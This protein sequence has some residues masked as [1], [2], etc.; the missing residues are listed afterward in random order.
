[1]GFYTGTSTDYK[2]ALADL[3]TIAITTEGTWNEGTGT[4]GGRYTTSTEDEWIATGDGS[5]SDTITVG[6]RTYSDEE[7]DWFNWEL[8]G[9]DQY[10]DANTWENQPGISSG[11]HDGAGDAAYGH[12]VPLCNRT[13][14]YWYSVTANRM[15]G[16]F[17][18]GNFFSSFYLGWAE[19]LD[20][21]GNY[22][23]PKVVAGTMQFPGRRFSE[24]TLY[25]SG[26]INPMGDNTAARNG[27][28]S[29]HNKAGSWERVL[30]RDISS[31]IASTRQP[32]GN[33]IHPMQRTNFTGSITGADS[34]VQTNVAA[35]VR[36]LSFGQV[37]PE[38][39]STSDYPG[40]QRAVIRRTPD[41]GAAQDAVPRFACIIQN[42]DGS[43]PL[44]KLDG[45]FWCSLGGGQT[46]PGLQPG[47]RIQDPDTS[48]YYRVF[49]MGWNHAEW[50]GLCI[51]EK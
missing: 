20:T 33:I 10:T 27:P 38:L 17:Q 3:R 44:A 50:N 43:A 42:A 16:V 8:A 5:G 34:W 7:G 45:V 6:I 18:V 30:N 37:I 9:M 46:D 40:N 32:S 22:A 31:N 11:R 36:P 19:R 29:V 35:S 12:Y 13:M 49:P 41:P 24:S 4:G 14:N 48:T 39:T 21:V 28:M 26:I 23:D 51:E 47:D 2:D 25:L 15:T 1:M